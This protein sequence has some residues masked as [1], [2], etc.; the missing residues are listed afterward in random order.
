[1]RTPFAVIAV[2]LAVLVPVGFA[3]DHRARKAG[4]TPVATIAA[5]V[6]TLRGLR[7]SELPRPREVTARQAA[8]DGLAD[9]DSGYPAAARH[10]DEALYTLLGLLPPGTD[11]RRVSGSV[12]DTQVAGYYDPR[13]K[14]L[15]IVKGAATANRVMTE[16]VIAHE[17]THALDDQDI[18]LDER[19]SERSDDPGYAYKALVE[20]TATEVMYGYVAR[21]FRADVALGGLLGGS[22]GGGTGTGELPPFV[23]AGLVFPYVAGQRFVDDLYHRAGRTWTLVNLAER[24]RPPTTTEQILHPG[25]WIAAEPPLPVTLPRPRGRGW[26]R[27]TTGTFGEWQTGQLLKRASAAVGWGG[28]RYALY[29]RGTGPCRTPCTARDALVMRW[30]LDSGVSVPAFA[31][32]LRAAIPQ[33]RVTVTRGRI[34]LVIAPPGVS[35]A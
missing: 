24:T 32:T 1:M 15:K 20:G 30:R 18:G 6:Q 23:V 3:T 11:L 35:T 7:Y 4:L 29:R 5:R 10:A 22:L 14:R 13:S 27:L 2:L 12:F 9:L 19:A 34:T 33:A 26:R 17:L 8:R 21:Y 16:M 25:K 31:G 28:D